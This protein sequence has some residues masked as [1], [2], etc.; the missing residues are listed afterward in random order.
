MGQGAS[1]QWRGGGEQT[2]AAVLDAAEEFFADRGFTAVTVRDTVA[3][4]SADQS[5]RIVFDMERL[6]SQA[7]RDERESRE[8]PALPGVQVR[9]V[10]FAGRTGVELDHRSKEDA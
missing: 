9:A 5:E 1:G 3:E 10:A 2:T 4:E 6:H 8:S 7:L